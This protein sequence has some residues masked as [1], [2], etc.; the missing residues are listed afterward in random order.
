VNSRRIVTRKDCMTAALRPPEDMALALPPTSEMLR[1]LPTYVSHTRTH[2]LFRTH[3]PIR[4]PSYSH[5]RTHPRT[6]WKGR[7]KNKHDGWQP[8]DW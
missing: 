2:P 7:E 1:D 8:T 4:E 6:G 5:P 3:A